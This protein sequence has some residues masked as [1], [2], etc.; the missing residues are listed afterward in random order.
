MT[1]PACRSDDVRVGWPEDGPLIQPSAQRPGGSSPLLVPLACK[2]CG[3]KWHQNYS[4][5]P[6]EGERADREA[7]A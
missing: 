5:P 7:K 3:H 1:C 2:K 4:P 6:T